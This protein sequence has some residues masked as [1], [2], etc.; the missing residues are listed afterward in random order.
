M[1]SDREG[2]CG[3][4]DVYI[5]RRSQG[6]GWSVPKNLGCDTTGGPN[7]AGA[8]A[9]PSYVAKGRGSLFFSSNVAGT[10]DLLVSRGKVWSGFGVARPVAELNTDLEDARPN[11]RKDGLEIVF[12]SNRTGTLGGFDIWS[13]TRRSLSSPWSA[14]A[15][16]GP[17]VNTV[18][19]NETRA[20]LSWDARTLLFGRAPGPEGQTDIFITTRGGRHSHS[21]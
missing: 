6:H 4:G 5:T 11:V 10:S 15:N 14:P 1:V 2:G 9:G 21:R 13:S 17:A 8:E 19:G 20:S 7:T 16:L 12:D 18:A 3:G